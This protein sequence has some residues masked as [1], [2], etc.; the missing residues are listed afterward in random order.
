[1]RESSMERLDQ[2][3]FRRGLFGSREQA[4]RAVYKR[5]RSEEWVILELHVEENSMEDAFRELTG[6]GR[7]PVTA[8]PVPRWIREV[9][10]AAS[11]SAA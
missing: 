1:M 10:V 5:I 9:W 4:R 8:T 2:L 11:A 6:A 3:L 7:V